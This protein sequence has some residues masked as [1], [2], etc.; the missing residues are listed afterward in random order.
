MHLSLKFQRFHLCLWALLLVIGS[1]PAHADPETQANAAAAPEAIPDTTGRVIV[2][3]E[4]DYF[5]S[6]DDRHYTQGAR[7]SYLSG[8]VTPQ[9]TWDDPYQWM[10]DHLPIFEGGDFKRKYDWTI[11]GQSLFTPKNLL[12]T[13][14]QS[15]DRPY[16][17]W[18]YTGV[19]FLQDTRHDTHDT[20]ENA[21]I[22]GGVVGPA[23][24]GNLTQNDWHQFIGVT[25][26][27]GWQN[28]IH[29]EPGI[30]LSYERKWRFEA[31][32]TG[33][34]GVDAIPEAGATAGNVFTYAETGGLVRL[35]QNLAA[36]YGPTHI[37]PSLSGT[38]WYDKTRMV[39]PY[40]W[41]LFAGMQGRAVERNIFLD[42]NTLTSSAYVNKRP[43]VADFLGGL[44]LL[45]TDA[46]RVDFTYTERTK[47]FYGPQATQDKFGGINLAFHF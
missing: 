18:L 43:L 9:G 20:L 15:R 41:Y 35:G 1:H 11:M 36:D 28:Q 16:A 3:E 7:V 5:V 25:A 14:A 34:F 42:G 4:N 47:E 45:W 46:L 26:A 13:S 29:N 44:S 6:N 27:R 31:P 12:T 33:N 39:G 8:A 19:G 32:I 17:G 22:L 21:E 23:A 37:R 40:G 24:F 10:S 2:T 30:V 38:D